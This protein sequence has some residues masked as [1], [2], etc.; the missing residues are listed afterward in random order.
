MTSIFVV[1]AINGALCPRSS[2]AV[3]KMNDAALW[4]QV[5]KFGVYQ[6]SNTERWVIQCVQQHRVHKAPFWIV[7]NCAK[8]HV[9]CTTFQQFAN[10]IK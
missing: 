9:V 1:K 7:N 5:C 10:A 2:R 4:N 8:T 3:Q 6:N